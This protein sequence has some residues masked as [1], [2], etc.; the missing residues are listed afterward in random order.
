[1]AKSWFTDSGKIAIDMFS[2]NQGICK[3][4][5]NFLI[6][7]SNIVSK[8]NNFQI[9]WPIGGTFSKL[10]MHPDQGADEVHQVSSIAEL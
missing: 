7:I 5:N 2:M 3:Q 10:G 9:L 8:N 1:M 6:N 4:Q